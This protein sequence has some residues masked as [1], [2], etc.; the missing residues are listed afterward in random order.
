MQ[1]VGLTFFSIRRLILLKNCPSTLA[2]SPLDTDYNNKHS[3]KR[4]RII[5][6]GLELGS[7]ND[8]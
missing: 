5:E 7:S 6:D 8:G 2:F 1:A 4:F 3:D